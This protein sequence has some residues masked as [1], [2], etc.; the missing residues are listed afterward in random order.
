MNPQLRWKFIFILIV[1]F[2]CIFGLVGL[3]EF[4]T[5]FATVKKNLADRI[6]LGLDLKG[7]SHLVLQVQVD[8]AIGQR[9][10]Q[11]VDE[12][13]KQLQDRKSVV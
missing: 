2:L 9:C 1:I 12:L 4:P 6:K 3:P 7:G 11:A 5:S 8:E 13:T 10:D